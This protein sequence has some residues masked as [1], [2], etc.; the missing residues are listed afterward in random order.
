MST[1]KPKPDLAGVVAE[2]VT[3]IRAQHGAEAIEREANQALS[4]AK[5]RT[6]VAY[7]AL[8]GA[9]LYGNLPALVRTPAGGLYLVHHGMLGSGLEVT[10]VNEDEA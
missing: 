7:K 6:D 5:K 10:L 3:A 1:V 8:T 4:E 9:V 2:Y